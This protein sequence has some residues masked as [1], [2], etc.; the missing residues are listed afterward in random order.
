VLQNKANVDHGKINIWESRPQ[1]QLLSSVV[2][3]F[4]INFFKFNNILPPITREKQH[5]LASSL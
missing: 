1:E 4:I 5:M 2:K 3:K